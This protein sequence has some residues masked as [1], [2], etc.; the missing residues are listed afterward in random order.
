MKETY[1][2]SSTGAT[3]WSSCLRAN[4]RK[5]KERKSLFYVKSLKIGGLGIQHYDII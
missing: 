3:R 5:K 2:R 4:K 1:F